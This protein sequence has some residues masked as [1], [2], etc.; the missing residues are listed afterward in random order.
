MVSYE[1]AVDDSSEE[2]GVVCVPCFGA[3]AK[4]QLHRNRRLG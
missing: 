2:F 4:L 3:V 1:F